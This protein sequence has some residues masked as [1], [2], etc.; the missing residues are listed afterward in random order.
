MNLKVTALEQEIERLSDGAELE[1]VSPHK[2]HTPDIF[3]TLKEIFS[4]AQ[5]SLFLYPQ[6]RSVILVSKRLYRPRF[7]KNKQRP[8]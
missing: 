8:Y 4:Q 1:N 2:M 7:K 6:I 5:L 3:C